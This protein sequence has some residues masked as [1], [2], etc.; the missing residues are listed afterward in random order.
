MKVTVFLLTFYIIL[1]NHRKHRGAEGSQE[2]CVYFCLSLCVFYLDIRI[3]LRI[4]AHQKYD[5]G[6]NKDSQGRTGMD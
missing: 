6:E 3:I 4:F 2:R 5:Y 1:K